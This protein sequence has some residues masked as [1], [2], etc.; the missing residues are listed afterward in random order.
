MHKTTPTRT[1]ANFIA[2]AIGEAM[3]RPSMDGFLCLQ[4]GFKDQ[5]W[6]IQRD[7]ALLFETHVHIEYIARLCSRMKRTNSPLK[8]N[9]DVLL[10]KQLELVHESGTCSSKLDTMQ[11]N[12]KSK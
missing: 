7:Q 12:P 10:L 9:L 4:H 1:F 8:K 11:R 2:H 6:L 5:L 3:T